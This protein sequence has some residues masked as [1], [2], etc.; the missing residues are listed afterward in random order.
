MEAKTISI[1]LGGLAS[2]PSDLTCA[3]GQTS[4]LANLA[5]EDGGLR[6]VGQPE[7]LG[8]VPGRY[9]PKYIHRGA[10]GAAHLICEGEQDGRRAVWAFAV[11]GDDWGATDYDV[12]PI[13][14]ADD[15]LP[16]RAVNAVTSVGNILAL[17]TDAGM[18]YALYRDGRYTALGA[19]P[20]APRI[21]WGANET[22]AYSRGMELR[23]PAVVDLTGRGKDAWK[24]PSD[25]QQ[26]AAQTFVDAVVGQIAEC[27]DKSD[28]MFTAPF[29]VRAA[30][31]LYDGTY[32]GHTPPVLITPNT[33]LPSVRIERQFGGF[34]NPTE[35]DMQIRD[36]WLY[37]RMTALQLTALLLERPRLGP[38]AD[39]VQS[40]DVFASTPVSTYEPPEGYDMAKL[41]WTIGRAPLELRDAH[42]GAEPQSG[43][44][45]AI[46]PSDVAVAK[47]VTYLQLPPNP[48]YDREIADTANYYRIAS[49]EPTTLD[50]WY[51]DDGA[52][53]MADYMP[54]P[55]D[56][57]LRN[58]SVRPKL[59]DD[60]ISQ[61]RVT[62]RVAKAYNARLNLAD[63]AVTPPMPRSLRELFR[64]D[65]VI[66]NSDT[67]A[68][69]LTIYSVANGQRV[70]RSATYRE[71]VSEMM[72]PHQGWQRWL[73][74]GDADAVALHID[75]GGALVR[76][77]VP[78]DAP[79]HGLDAKP[80]TD[81]ARAPEVSGDGDTGG[82]TAGGDGSLAG[83]G[84]LTGGDGISGGGNTDNGRQED[85]EWVGR[86]N[87]INDDGLQPQ[88]GGR[89]G[90]DTTDPHLGVTYLVAHVRELWIALKPHDMLNGAYWYG[91][92][93]DYPDIEPKMTL[94]RK[95]TAGWSTLASRPD[96]QALPNDVAYYAEQRRPD[97]VVGD[98]SEWGASAEM[99]N[100]MLTSVPEN[101]MVYEAKSVATIGQGRTLALAT[102]TRALSQGQFGSHPMYALTTEGV[103]SLAIDKTGAYTAVQ[104]LS[105]E[106]CVNPR[107]VCEIDGGVLFPAS[108]GV[109]SL[110]GSQCECLSAQLGYTAP[111]RYAPMDIDTLPHLGKY[112]AKILRDVPRLPATSLAGM[113]PTCRIVCDNARGRVY[114]FAPDAADH[115]AYVYSL[116]TQQWGAV[117]CDV[118]GSLNAYPEALCVD[119]GNNI[120]R[121]ADTSVD[122]LTMMV[123][124]PLKLLPGY[125]T[126]R[127][128]LMRGDYLPSGM[129]VALYGSRDMH[130]WHLV[131]AGRG[132]ELRG[133]SGTP[134]RYY[135][136]AVCATLAPSH[137]ISQ[138][139]LAFVLRLLGRLR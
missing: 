62:A 64:A 11:P 85:F 20:A 16:F 135:R 49:I 36:V 38:W 26:R 1:P 8:N 70:R 37:T 6:P 82:T 138:A 75:F 91:G 31:R 126:I 46:E 65:A 72:M 15:A 17:A 86:D 125:A 58:L 136:L 114:V 84:S 24:E 79:T 90:N 97:K 9:T 68:T 123:T 10:D 27:Q 129:C 23:L 108:K 71:A 102:A 77:P 25:D 101:P 33:A 60:Y 2:V 115:I 18:T 61:C 96:L 40:L 124:R 137:C 50:S 14:V 54:I 93:Y 21:R 128:L 5:A 55:L 107:G 104:P 131:W 30:W 76:V 112:A 3:N 13:V 133:I 113:M 99:P 74:V 105:R 52:T 56:D 43:S 12:A 106:V 122:V 94:T 66:A 22:T 95:P 117:A 69:T 28:K 130:S 47:L 59:P 35:D 110:H 7:Q 57:D 41:G 118:A 45:V 89:G 39:L 51:A 42:Q 100:K 103:W 116:K 73:Y 29:F 120:V 132:D 4:L 53:A 88:G 134:Y 19:L 63:V 139:D 92:Y 48:K 109:M 44:K 78:V 121:F 34:R 119:S 81:A 32:V 127:Q 98:D 67:A 83:G 111:T 87:N 80:L